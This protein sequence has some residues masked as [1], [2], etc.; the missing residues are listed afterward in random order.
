MMNICFG[1][2]SY[3]YNIKWLSST[4]KVTKLSN[5]SF[6]LYH[7]P[8]FSHIVVFMCNIGDRKIKQCALE[9]FFFVCFCSSNG[10]LKYSLS[11]WNMWPNQPGTAM[12]HSSHRKVLLGS[13]GMP[14]PAMLAARTW[15]WYFLFSFRSDTWKQRHKDTRPLHIQHI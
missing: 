3:I 13:D 4:L 14:T 15:N 5:N 10:S 6:F 7:L 8:Y 11:W 9:G 1:I 12:V 2:F